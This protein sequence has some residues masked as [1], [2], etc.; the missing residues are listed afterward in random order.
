MKPTSATRVTRGLPPL[1][2]R[3]AVGHG[4]G[5]CPGGGRRATLL[6]VRSQLGI[7]GV[8]AALIGPGCGGTVEHGEAVATGAGAR[9]GAGGRPAVASDAGGGDGGTGARAPADAGLTD[10]RYVDPGC[11]SRPKV[12]GVNECDAYDVSSCGPGNR[13]SPYVS[14]GSGCQAEEI[15]TR[16]EVAGTGVQGD[17]CTSDACAPG[18]VCVS[19]GAG[20]ECARLCKLQGGGAACPPGL[21]CAPLDVDGFFVCG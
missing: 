7:L 10:A 14:Y 21:L 17:D 8:V 18:Y 6:H 4:A 1:P 20:F 5:A 19:A 15:G 11:P 2:A 16:C 9:S 3:A 12:P 13:C